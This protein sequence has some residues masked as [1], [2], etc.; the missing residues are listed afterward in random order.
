MKFDFNCRSD[1]NYWSGQQFSMLK[2]FPTQFAIISM[3]CLTVKK[4]EIRTHSPLSTC[5]QIYE[6]MKG[7]RNLQHL[8]LYFR[9][10][11]SDIKYNYSSETLKDCKRLT[12]F[13]LDIPLIS[14]V[15]FVKVG[16]HLP[17]IRYINLQKVSLSFRA[18]HL[19][20]LTRLSA[21]III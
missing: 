7:F 11:A 5:S 4:V 12:H 8:I 13:S 10:T 16:K 17:L 21:T 14:K 3:V 9:Y 20:K 15:F 18:H 6:T 2:L 19:S 1:T